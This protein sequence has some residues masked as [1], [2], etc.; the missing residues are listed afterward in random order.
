VG[1]LLLV[2]SMLFTVGWFNRDML[3]D[4]L[5]DWY[6]EN[7]SGSLEIGEVDATFINGFPNVGFTIHN[8]YQTSFD[9]ILDKRTSIFIEKT[10]VSIAATD[11]LSG[12]IRFRNI[13]IDN[14]EIESEVDSEKSL[15]KYI[16]LK[17]DKQADASSGLLLPLWFH[18]DRTN[19]LLREVKFI[20]RDTMLNKYFNLDIHQVTGKIRTQNK[21]IIGN[22]NFNVTVNDL[23]FNTKKGSYIN[24]ALVSG[25]PEFVL[26]QQTN[27]LKVKQFPL[28]IDQQIFS[29]EAEFDF[30]NINS[31]SFNL[32]NPKTDFQELK[33]LLPDNLTRKLSAYSILE[34]IATRLLLEGDF[35]YGDIPIV[36]GEFETTNNRI[37]INDSLKVNAVFIKGFLTNLISRDENVTYLKP[38]KKDIKVFFE[39]LRGNLDDV[40]FSASN[41]YYQTTKEALNFVK[42]NVKMSGSNETLARLIQTSNFDFIG[43]NFALDTHISGDISQPEKIFDYASGDFSIN[44]TRVVLQKNNLQLPVEVLDIRLNQE[45]STLE[46]LKINLPNGEHLIFSGKVTN[47]SSLLID[48]PEMPAMVEV[49]LDSEKLNINQLV[50]TAMEFIPDDEKKKNRTTT[51]H[52]TIE[53]IYEKF[54]P[55]F[56]LNLNTVVYDSIRLDNLSADIRLVN[57]ETIQLNKLRFE[58]NN[59]QTELD[60]TLR[61][62]G[63]DNKYR[64]PLFININAHTSGPLLVFQELFKIKLLKIN[65][66]NFE[67]SGNLTGNIQ[68]FEQLLNNANGDLRLKNARLY[69]P[70]ADLNIALDSMHVA[71]HDSEIKLD[72]FLI[73]IDDHHPIAMQGNI[74]DFPGFLLDNLKRKGKI[75]LGMESSYIDL[76]HWIETIHS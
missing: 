2:P 67:F 24:G 28:N 57:A 29:T 3:I 48:Q 54:Q 76:D 17:K 46:K 31:Y 32:T 51:L 64:E 26:D 10:Q 56:N 68:K 37:I 12:D 73:E 13:E 44:N 72:R 15:A 23:G 47:I 7:N 38:E 19:F 18:P 61:I 74:S 14:A 52:E 69:Y 55:S 70:E 8:I 36:Q 66:G 62:P 4:E 60:G 34:P 21:D 11:L 63:V 71:V 27:L 25:N 58:Y 45:Y 65:S 22:I 33:A 50:T 9:T 40:E 75:N 30:N 6:R 35:Q 5:Q 41:S 16:R 39:E 20:S 59:A 1:F 49:S 42:A 43:G 53:T